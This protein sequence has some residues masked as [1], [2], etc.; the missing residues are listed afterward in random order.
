MSTWINPAEGHAVNLDH[1]VS[2]RTEEVNLL[3]SE[4]SVWQVYGM[5]PGP[6]GD[7]IVLWSANDKDEAESVFSAIMELLDSKIVFYHKP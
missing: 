7:K 2:I 4:G 3:T 6:D 1:L 5:E